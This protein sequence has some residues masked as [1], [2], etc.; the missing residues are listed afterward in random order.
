MY[1]LFLA[2]VLGDA[3]AAIQTHGGGDPS[4]LLS[5]L[6]QQEADDFK[7]FEASE[8]F[9]YGD[10]WSA[11][12]NGVMTA[13][14]LADSPVYCHTG[15]LPAH[16]R[17]MGYVT[18]NPYPGAMCD[19]DRGV[20]LEEGLKF[21]S[22][23]M[24]LCHDKRDRQDCPA[25]LQ[26]DYK[27]FFL[28]SGDYK[29]FQTMLVPNDMEQEIDGAREPLGIVL[30]CGAGCERDECPPGTLDLEALE[31]E[32]ALVQVNGVAVG[33]VVPYENCY[34]L[35]DESG[36]L[37]WASDENGQYTIGIRVN[38]PGNYM[39]IGSVIVW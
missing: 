19:Y 29:G 17:F 12:F 30:I 25:L 21:Q 38:V 1:S 10:K 27:D 16:A 6:R 26:I 31:H 33:R 23:T 13:H 24:L 15:R 7:T 14:Q 2:E 36:G 4:V 18:D 35:A 11:A 34:L 39:R 28:A 9:L 20:E 3:L 32:E 8:E 37:K 5:Q 22:S